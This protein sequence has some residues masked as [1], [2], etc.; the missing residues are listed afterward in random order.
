MIFLKNGESF[1]RVN[2]WS[3]IQARES[4]YPKLELNDQQLSDVFGYYD[5]LPEEIP[6]G[7]SNCRKGHK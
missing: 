1:I 7:K 5:D 3:E 4:Y 2:D 6:C